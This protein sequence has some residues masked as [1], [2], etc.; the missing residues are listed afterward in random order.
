MNC[1]SRSDKTNGPDC[2]L[3]TGTQRLVGKRLTRDDLA[4]TLH[5]RNVTRRYKIKSHEYIQPK[6]SI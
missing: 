5:R 3:V 2:A 6:T 1:L 4:R